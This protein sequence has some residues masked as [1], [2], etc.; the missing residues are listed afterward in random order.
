MSAYFRGEYQIVRRTE[1]IDE[2]ELWSLSRGTV[3]ESLYL[4]R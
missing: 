3:S 4:V 2:I 1:P